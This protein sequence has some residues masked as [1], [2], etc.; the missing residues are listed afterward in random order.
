M[1]HLESA[2]AGKNNLWRYIVML[3]A[4]FLAI[5]TIGAIP[6]IT[7]MSLR[8][9]ADPETA[10]RMSSN[11][12]DLSLLGFGSNMTL[13]MV[14]FPFLAGL[15]AFILLIKPLHGRSFSSI[16]N[17][18]SSIRW[19]RIFLSGLLWLILSAAY[20]FI[21]IGA[22]P[23]NFRLNN[24]SSD[25]IFLI[26]VSLLFIP[27][28][29][30]LEEVLFRGYLMQ[31]F[32]VVFRNRWMPVII[33]G[34]L[35][36]I[37]HSW[38][39]E[40]REFGFWVMIPQYLLF[41]ILFGLITIID[42]GIEVAVGAHAANNVFISIMVTHNSSVIQTKAVYEQISIQPWIESGA[43]LII[44]LVFLLLAKKIFRWNNLSVLRA[45]IELPGGSPDQIS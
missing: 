13:F 15:I 20:L 23:Q 2:F 12:G 19:K 35:F 39:P 45:G 37:M 6:L 43:L 4:V 27:F 30:S 18:T 40:I 44:S 25:F 14:L 21:Y 31:G 9:L 1:K 32:A 42:D 29:A 5:N 24:I 22:D 36:G 10:S 33:T 38:N 11:P 16:V 28:Q 8:T 34:C 41:G 7:G 3:V 17:G 26:M